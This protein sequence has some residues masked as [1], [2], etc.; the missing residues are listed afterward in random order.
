MTRFI[1]NRHGG[2]G[3]TLTTRPSKLQITIGIHDYCQVL[4]FVYFRY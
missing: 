3:M 4:L 2:S 1:Q